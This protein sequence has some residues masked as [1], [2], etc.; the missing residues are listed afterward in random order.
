MAGAQRARRPDCGCSVDPCAPAWEARYAHAT[1]RSM[2][3]GATTKPEA[4][5]DLPPAHEE[6]GGT[7][8]PNPKVW[9]PPRARCHHRGQ[10]AHAHGPDR[11]RPLHSQRSAPNLLPHPPHPPK[12]WPTPLRPQYANIITEPTN[13]LPCRGGPFALCYYSGLAPLPC[14][15]DDDGRFATCDCLDI[16]YGTYF[17]DINAILDHAVYQ[18]TVKVCG[19]DGSGCT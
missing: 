11:P 4:K 7:G 3:R 6:P 1:G 14:T 15:V 12:F 13:F 17:V 5:V 16:T 2:G 8:P 10:P 18:Q 9:P 19:V